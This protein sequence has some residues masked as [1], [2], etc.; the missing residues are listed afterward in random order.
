MPLSLRL[1]IMFSLEIPGARPLVSTFRSSLQ[2]CRDE[3]REDWKGCQ[4]QSSSMAPHRI[5]RTEHRLFQ[6]L[7][8]QEFW[9]AVLIIP[10]YRGGD[11]IGKV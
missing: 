3:V 1:L 2:P 10:L 6:F 8:S 7:G 11:R 9:E 4:G 5:N